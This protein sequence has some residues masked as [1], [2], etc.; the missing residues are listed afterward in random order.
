MQPLATHVTRGLPLP[1]FMPVIFS[2][3]KHILFD[4]FII[5]DGGYVLPSFYQLV[6]AERQRY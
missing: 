2:V 3:S 1:A 4:Y 5:I 6:S